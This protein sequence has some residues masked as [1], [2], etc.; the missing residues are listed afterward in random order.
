MRK[1]GRLGAGSEI[2][3]C[4]PEPVGCAFV[5][6]GTEC[7]AQIAA[8]IGRKL[9]RVGVAD[10]IAEICRR[11]DPLA[12]G[13][14]VDLKLQVLR[15]ELADDDRF[16]EQLRRDHALTEVGREGTGTSNDTDRLIVRQRAF[17][18]GNRLNRLFY[19]DQ[20]PQIS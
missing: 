10:A 2:D 7:A 20:R 8:S 14:L 3:N 5:S 15:L 16:P 1:I 4:A 18:R 11:S 12:L 9:A 13:E 6:P 19:V 17:R